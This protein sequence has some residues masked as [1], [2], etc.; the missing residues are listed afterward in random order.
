MRLF[1][2]FALL[3]C[4]SAPHAQDPPKTEPRPGLIGV[5]GD[6][7]N[8]VAVPIPLVVLGGGST[9]VDAAM[10][11]FAQAANGGDVAIL[12]TSGGTAYNPYLFD[13]APV[14]SV[15]TYRVASRELALNPRLGQVLRDME[16]VFLAGGDQATY[17]EHWENT[18]V[19]Q[20]LS[21]LMHEKRG[22]IGGTSAGAMFLGGFVFDARE[23]T[24]TSEEALL[25]PM[26]NLVSVRRSAFPPPAF[27]EDWIVDTHFSERNRMGRLIA[28]L[29]RTYENGVC[30]LGLDEETAVVIDAEG[31]ARTMGEGAAWIIC[32][33]QD[34]P[35]TVRA[36]EPLDW[37]HE[38]R[39]LKVVQVPAHQSFSMARESIDA[40]LPT[41]HATVVQG[42]LHLAPVV[43]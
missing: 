39:P 27:L 31:H 34:A 18:Q 12:R 42:V 20:A 13:L 38:G 5:V 26:S 2:L 11:L 3:G 7:A 10:R 37:S 36:G 40:L 29:A 23:G 9:D 8:H 30:G 41:H 35:P 25:N 14:N 32:P 16:A 33:V 21:F 28:F 6:T 19:S 17:F 15:E 24:V 1:L 22:A 43:P 4:A